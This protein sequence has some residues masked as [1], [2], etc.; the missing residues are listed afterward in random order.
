MIAHHQVARQIQIILLHSL[1]FY[2][3]LCDIKKTLMESNTE[4]VAHAL[5]IPKGRGKEFKEE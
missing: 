5:P 4:G 1:C 3:I 2:V